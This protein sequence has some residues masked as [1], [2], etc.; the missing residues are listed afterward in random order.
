MLE[1]DMMD[2]FQIDRGDDRSQDACGEFEVVAQSGEQVEAHW[3]AA[4]QIA[5]EPA[6]IDQRSRFLISGLEAGDLGDF[7]TEE[8]ATVVGGGLGH[9]RADG[10]LAASVVRVGANRQVLALT[11]QCLEKTR[12]SAEAVVEVFEDFVLLQ[13]VRRNDRQL[14]DGLIV[15]GDHEN[16]FEAEPKAAAS[17]VSRAGVRN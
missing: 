13:H 16:S 6:L 2:L 3:H 9:K 4:Q 7:G 12:A 14:G 15:D 1:P 5:V 8:I 17:K 11:P 10:A